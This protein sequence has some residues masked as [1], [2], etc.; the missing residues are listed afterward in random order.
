MALKLLLS[1][2]RGNKMVT[3]VFAEG[4]KWLSRGR[5]DVAAPVQK[6]GAAGPILCYF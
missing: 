2:L 3:L 4:I 6:I 5:L 1:A